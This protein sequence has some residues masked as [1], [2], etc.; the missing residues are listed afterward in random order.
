MKR[1]ISLL[2]RFWLQV[3]EALKVSKKSSVAV[4]L[5]VK[6][7]V[8]PVHVNLDLLKSGVPTEFFNELLET[9]QQVLTNCPVDTNLVCYLRFN[10]K[11]LN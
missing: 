4:D 2:T 7:G 3:L 9:A 6:M 8:F 1:C 5:L 10:A 11:R